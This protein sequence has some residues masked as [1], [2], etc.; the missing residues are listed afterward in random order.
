MIQD[1]FDLGGGKISINLQSRFL[2]DLFLPAVRDQ[3]ITKF[4]CPPALPDNG[5][6]YG[7]SCY[8]VPYDHC[9]PLVR[10]SDHRNVRSLRSDLAHGFH[11]HSKLAGPNL[12]R[13]M[14]H[15]AG[16]RKILGKLLLGHTA[17][18]ALFVK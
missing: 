9:F 14:F 17:D 4:C 1:P 3:L 6:A 12:V 7:F 2:P 18:P 13:V 8:L 15:P 5:T 10:N 11:C 16:L